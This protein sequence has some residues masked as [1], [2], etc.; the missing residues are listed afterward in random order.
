MKLSEERTGDR[1]TDKFCITWREQEEALQYEIF[2]RRKLLRVSCYVIGPHARGIEVGVGMWWVAQV[3]QHVL[4]VCGGFL[5]VG[6]VSVGIRNTTIPH[7]K[8]CE[9]RGQSRISHRTSIICILQC[10]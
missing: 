9:G 4:G 1:R 3:A 5:T 6:R 7:L 10:L 8:C 2:L